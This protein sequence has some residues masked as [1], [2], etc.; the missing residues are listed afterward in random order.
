MYGI[1]VKGSTLSIICLAP[2]VKQH[3]KVSALV[4]LKGYCLPQKVVIKIN[5][6]VVERRK[7]GFRVLLWFFSQ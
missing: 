5:G 1:C 4:Y 2:I 3:G 6:G 7:K